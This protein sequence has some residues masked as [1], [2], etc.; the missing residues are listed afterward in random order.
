MRTARRGGQG[1]AGHPS[2][3][4]EQPSRADHHR[5]RRLLAAPVSGGAPRTE[6]PVSA[7][8]L[9][10]KS[11]RGRTGRTPPAAARLNTN[12]LRHPILAHHGFAP[13][14][15][16]FT[17]LMLRTPSPCSHRSSASRPSFA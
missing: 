9:A 10:G 11:T 17:A 15:A 13:V 2:A 5:S 16:A 12:G 8:P 4:A 14:S 6:P 3:R 7:P 1:A